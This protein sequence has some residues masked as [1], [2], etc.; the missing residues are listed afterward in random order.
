MNPRILVLTT[1]LIWTMGGLLL[2]LI[3]SSNTFTIMSIGL[4]A[5][6]VFNF[7]FLKRAGGFNWKIVNVK[8]VIFS[9]FGY[10]IY[11]L[12]FLTC[13]DYYEGQVSVPLVLNY[14]WPFFTGL[15]TIIFYKR[16]KFGLQF[17]LSALL[18][19]L[20]VV[21]LFSKGDISSLNLGQSM[22]GLLFG[23]LAGISYGLF[24]A[25]SSTIK[26]ERENLQFLFIG[27]FLSGILLLC[28]SVY[29]YG[30]T[31]FELSEFDWIIAFA[32]GLILDSL[33]YY[34]WT[35]A[36][37]RAAEFNV[38]ISTVTSIVNFLP[39]LSILLVS[40]VFVDER[41]EIFRLYF[42]SALALVFLSSY[43]GN[44]SANAKKTE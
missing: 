22:I 2:K 35:T 31:T 5:S 27:T 24:S 26:T 33:G 9:L 30:P 17:I 36:N 25:F 38:E 44:M 28:F 12:F 43:I 11:W 3:S 29:R 21:M 4:I 41:T 42:I 7:L 37:R 23:L 10:F 15:F 14:T 32:N 8:T 34:L 20:G 18:G 19:I 39:I 16:E 6:A 13:V 40:I 1:T